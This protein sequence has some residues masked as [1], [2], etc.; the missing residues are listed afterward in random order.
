MQ[1]FDQETLRLIPGETPKEKHENAKE[2][3][4][5]LNSIAYPRRGTWEDSSGLETFA[6]LIQEILPYE[7]ARG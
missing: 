1:S 5:I 7:Q 3:I 6:T 2:L 4:R